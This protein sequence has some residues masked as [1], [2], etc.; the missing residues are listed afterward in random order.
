M[1][2]SVRGVE[3]RVLN[4]SCPPLFEDVPDAPQLFEGCFTEV[5]WHVT[6]DIIFQL[7]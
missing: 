5:G 7:A 6:F 2:G 3:G 1:G 4:H